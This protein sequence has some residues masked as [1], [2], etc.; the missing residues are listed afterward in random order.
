M[1]IGCQIWEKVH[2]FLNDIKIQFNN[3]FTNAIKFSNPKSRVKVTADKEGEFVRIS[4]A[5]HGI[6]MSPDLMKDIFDIKKRTTRLGTQQEIGTG[7]GMPLEKKFINAYG[8]SIAIESVDIK[9]NSK[10]H[11]TKVSLLLKNPS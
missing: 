3:L 2:L 4:V 6:G 5:D 11:G 10:N 7:F 8:G 9:E 1:I